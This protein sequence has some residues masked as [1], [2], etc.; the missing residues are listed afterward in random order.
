MLSDVFSPAAT[1]ETICLDQ[2]SSSLAT[3]TLT[4][5]GTNANS[6]PSLRKLTKD[7]HRCDV[8]LSR[9]QNSLH[10]VKFYK[11]LF[12]FAFKN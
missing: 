1:T 12:I 2:S 4:S 7:L 6:E 5:T 11:T 10:E 3:P 9:Y 8:S